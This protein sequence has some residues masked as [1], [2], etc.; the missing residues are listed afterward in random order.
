MVIKETFYFILVC[1]LW[2]HCS[3]ICISEEGRTIF[4]LPSHPDELEL[5]S[6]RRDAKGQRH[7]RA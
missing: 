2:I 3:F 5:Y 6:K 1:Q 7:V 4:K